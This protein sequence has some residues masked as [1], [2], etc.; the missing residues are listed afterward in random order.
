MTSSHGSPC[1]KKK[2]KTLP[3]S[4]LLSPTSPA[5]LPLPS[6]SN[7]RAPHCCGLVL[8]RAPG[9]E[10]ETPGAEGFLLGALRC[11]LMGH[12]FEHA[13]QFGGACG[14]G[15]AIICFYFYLRVLILL[16]GSEGVTSR[17]RKCVHKTQP[18]L[19]CPG[20]RAFYAR[21]SC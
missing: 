14:H 3:N 21:P 12:S 19:S 8:P 18:S 1:F 11:A 16:S 4:Y 15:C 20:L 7:T 6:F 9:V 13:A 5:L 17:P 2:K 10:A